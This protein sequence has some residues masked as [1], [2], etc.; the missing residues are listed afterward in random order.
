MSKTRRSYTPEFKAEAVRLVIEQGMKLT[1]AARDLGIDKSTLSAWVANARETD[2]GSTEQVTQTPQ[3]MAAELRRLR[4][5]NA[6][7]KE[8]REILKKAA[9]FFAKETR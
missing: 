6:I 4:R 2:G 9:A 5:E 7:L 1:V 8:E 3:E